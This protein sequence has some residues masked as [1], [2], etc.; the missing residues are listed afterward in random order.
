MD[1]KYCIC[2]FTAEIDGKVVKGKCK[3]KEEAKVLL[4]FEIFNNIST[5]LTQNVLL[6]KDAYD[7]AIAEG[8]GAYLL[9][10]DGE[11]IHK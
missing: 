6:T 3:E 9:E 1:E 8:H 11:L 10:Q 7:D 2:E 5:T 4:L